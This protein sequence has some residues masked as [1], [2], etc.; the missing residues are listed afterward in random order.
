MVTT[1]RVTSLAHHLLLAGPSS[2][3]Y[4]A[5][6][7]WMNVLPSNSFFP[8][9]PI[10]CR[11]RHRNLRPPSLFSRELTAPATWWWDAWKS[12]F[13]F[14]FDKRCAAAAGYRIFLTPFLEIS[15]ERLDWPSPRTA[16]SRRNAPGNT[17]PSTWEFEKR[18]RRRRR[19][20]R[21]PFKHS[22]V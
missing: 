12:F 9:V 14:L 22:Q 13:L 1:D 6:K 20:R 3:L 4:T 21:T 7:L 5:A 10:Y 16:A 18:R 2:L 19:R 11:R 8:F 15:W 17:K